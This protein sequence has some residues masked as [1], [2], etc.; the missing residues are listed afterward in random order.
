MYVVAREGETFEELFRRFKRGIEA[1]GHPPRLP[2]QAAFQAERT[3]SGATRSARLS[4]S[5]GARGRSPGG[6]PAREPGRR[7]AALR[8]PW[9]GPYCPCRGTDRDI[10]DADTAA[11]TAALGRGPPTCPTRTG[12]QVGPKASRRPPREWAQIVCRAW[13]RSTM[14]VD[15]LTPTLPQP[16]RVLV[17][18]ATRRR[19]W[20]RRAARD[21]ARREVCALATR[22]EDGLALRQPV[23]PDV[24]LV[25][26]E[27]PG[28]RRSA[29]SPAW[30]ASRR[31]RVALGLIPTAERRCSRR[32]S[33]LRPE[34]RRLE[35]LYA[36]IVPPR[37]T[38]ICNRL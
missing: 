5:G 26:A 23:R 25:D 34:G 3:R 18:D 6:R 28:T 31:P 8:I 36:A 9:E 13:R 21:H 4:G 22:R 27:L 7:R 1:A 14:A 37:S 10:E 29:L 17:I 2:S 15:P 30:R 38:S 20:A 32:G 12:L 16:L 11:G 33:R 24:V 35:A 19:A